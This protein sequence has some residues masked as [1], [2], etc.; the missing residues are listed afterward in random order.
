[1]EDQAM[2]KYRLMFRVDEQE[3]RY[4]ENKAKA[5]KCRSVS[6]YM[7]SQCIHGRIIQFE[8]H[9]IDFLKRQVAGACNNINQIAHVA[10]ATKT[11]EPSAIAHMKGQIE[12]M[13][14]KLCQLKELFEG[15]L[16]GCDQH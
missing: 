15:S 1:L 8:G 5:A 11:V 6:D 9:N 14:S 2:R 3:K 4:I 7:R 10:N 16:H 13:F 12:D